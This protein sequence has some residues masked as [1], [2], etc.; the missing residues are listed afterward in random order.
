MGKVN[1]SSR[2]TCPLVAL[3]A[4]IS[5]LFWIYSDT[6]VSIVS[7]WSKSRTFAHGYLIIPIS[8]WLIWTKRHELVVLTPAPDFRPLLVLP[9][10]G[11]VWM[12]AHLAS[13]QLVQQLSVVAVVPF[14]VWAFLGTEVAR[15][16]AFPLGF[17]LFAVP[18]GEFLIPYLIDFTADFTVKMVSLTGIPI[19]RDGY[20]F[21]LPSGDWSVVKACSGIHY[22]IASVTLGFLFAYLTYRRFWRRLAFIVLA[23][24]FPVFANGIRAFLIVMIGHFSG[25]RLAVGVDHVLYGWLFFGL[26]M[27]IMFK[28]GMLWKEDD[29]PDQDN[30]PVHPHKQMTSSPARLCGVFVCALIVIGMWP[31]YALAIHR[32]TFAD[33]AHGVLDRPEGVTPWAAGANSGSGWQPAYSGYTEMQQ[34]AYERTAEEP[35]VVLFLYYYRAQKQDAELVNSENLLIKPND[36]VNQQISRSRFSIP[37]SDGSLPFIQTRLKL[38][39]NYYVVWEWYWVDGTPAVNPAYTKYLEIRQQLLGNGS[40]GF[41]I[42]LAT[43]YEDDPARAGDRLRGFA[44]SMLPSIERV[45]VASNR[46]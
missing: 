1:E 9:L 4:C 7:T 31:F 23:T 33:Q 27:L 2:W 10:I 38:D 20:F 45:L 24:V 44:E 13:I 37:T 29:I 17:L 6:V 39:G 19:Y 30:V 12:V 40:G 18:A 21:S 8:A 26:V 22:L 35:P 14:L 46:E 32:T 25:M 3:T 34:A 15:T 11:F 41:A 5:G 43:R 36:S 28:I 42:V 16:I